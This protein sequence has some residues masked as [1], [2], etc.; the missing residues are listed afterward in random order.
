MFV[1][2]KGMCACM[3]VRVRACVCV[4]ACMCVCVCVCVHVCVRMRSFIYSAET[5]VGGPTT[6]CFL[7]WTVTDSIVPLKRYIVHMFIM[8]RVSV[9]VNRLQLAGCEASKKYL[10]YVRTQIAKLDVSMP[11]R[12]ELKS[13]VL[14]L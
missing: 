4:C 7:T 14:L 2:A 1:T 12:S 3:C 10:S 8:I 9:E 6:D 5:R 11:A 13:V